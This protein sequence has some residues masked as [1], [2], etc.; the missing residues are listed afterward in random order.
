MTMKLI[1]L[2]TFTILSSFLMMGCATGR[3][4]EST[5]AEVSPSTALTSSY[6]LDTVKDM[7]EL[8]SSADLVVH[9]VPT[10]EVEKI[11]EGISGLHATYHQDI[12]IKEVL[13]G[14]S[15]GLQV[16]VVRGGVNQEA[17]EPLKETNPDAGVF[18]EDAEKLGGPLVPGDQIL[19]LMLSR[20]EPVYA[21][22]VGSKQGQFLLDQDGCV[23]PGNEFTDFDG[24]TVDEVQRKIEEL[25]G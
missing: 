4:D 22:V 2:M 15:P 18:I 25:S 16:R 6:D 14:Q 7:R 9:A 13:K 1:Y 21:V 12:A 11:V 19:F 3:V 24:L 20:T 23:A 5:S 17:R 10:G 8:V